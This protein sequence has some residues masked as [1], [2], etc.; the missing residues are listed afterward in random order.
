MT[1]PLSRVSSSGDVE[2]VREWAPRCHGMTP[3][4]PHNTRTA[5]GMDAQCGL[6][7]HRRDMIPRRCQRASEPGIHLRPGRS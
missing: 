5:P 1:V 4:F 6:V 3:A 2:E 7:E